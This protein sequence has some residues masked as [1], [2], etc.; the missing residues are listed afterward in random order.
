MKKENKSFLLQKGNIQQNVFAT[1][2]KSNPENRPMSCRVAEGSALPAE[3]GTM[4]TGV[5]H[6]PGTLPGLFHFSP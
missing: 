4:K 5:L 1:N 6:M 3:C 2:Y